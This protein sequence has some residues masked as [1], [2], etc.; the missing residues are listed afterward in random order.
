MNALVMH[1][2]N[3]KIEREC[4]SQH[5]W[6]GDGRPIMRVWYLIK[7]E[8]D[9]EK[10]NVRML[11]WTEMC[12]VLTLT[13][14]GSPDDPCLWSMFWS[15]PGVSAFHWTKVGHNALHT[16]QSNTRLPTNQPNNHKTSALNKQSVHILPLCKLNNKESELWKY[17]GRLC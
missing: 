11:W 17:R 9:S 14:A 7:S 2:L 15:A 8:V 16:N 5:K 1:E 13:H 12:W 6:F 10:L 3:M 4:C